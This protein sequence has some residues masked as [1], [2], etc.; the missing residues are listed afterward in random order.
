MRCHKR[1]TPNRSTPSDAG[2]LR[3]GRMGS[4]LLS[5]EDSPRFSSR[6]GCQARL[7][8]VAAS[9]VIDPAA[10]SRLRNSLTTRVRVWD[11]DA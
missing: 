6:A 1:R 4:G 10:R 5:P 11:D 2:Y 7:R 9:R 3:R 8:E